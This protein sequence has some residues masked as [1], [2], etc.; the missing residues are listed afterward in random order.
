MDFSPVILTVSQINTYIKSI[1]DADF[2]L[3][4][5]FL[6]GEISNFTNHYKTGHF[7]FTL[8]DDNSSIRAVMFKSSASRIKFAPDNGMRVVL[9]GRVSLFEATGQYQIYVD[10]M[11]PDGIGSLNLAYEQ[12]KQKLAD[13]GLFNVSNK[14][15]IPKYPNKIGVITSPTGAAVKDILTI[16]ERRFPLS[17]ILF[18]PSLV[19]GENAPMQLINGLNELE[20]RNVDTIIIG[21]GGGSIEDLWAFNDEKLA[22]TIFSL[23]TPVISAVGH[24]T[25]Y[26]ICD[27]VSDLRAATPSAGAELAVPD[28][29]DEK[30][31]VNSISNAINS[32]IVSK[33]KSER[34]R[35]D[36]I[37]SIPFFASPTAIFESKRM[38]VLKYFSDLSYIKKQFINHKRSLFNESLIKLNSLS[39][40]TTMARGYV[41]I[42]DEYN[43]LITSGKSLNIGDELK[44][45]FYDEIVMCEVKHKL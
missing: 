35:V 12:L 34:K 27:F 16:L 11:Q 33:I 30:K 36:E 42:T 37:K 32:L 2:N 18:Y 15:A 28:K 41:P 9:R 24:E 14:K 21:R 43:K 38:M 40:L 29:I 5:V 13:E 6:I 19:Q 45:N 44:I 23:N 1:F 25:D 39:P 7:Y 17:E 31:Y 3:Q 22:R 26:T 20:S 10:D 4:N 8:K